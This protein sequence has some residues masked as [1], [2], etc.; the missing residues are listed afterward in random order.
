MGSGIVIKGAESVKGDLRRFALRISLRY[1]IAAGLWILFSDQIVGALFRDANALLMAQTYKGMAFVLVTSIFLFL[2]LFR[3]MQLLEEERE[4]TA[5]AQE[6]LETSEQ[7]YRNMATYSL[8]PKFVNQGGRVVYA[9]PA[10]AALFGVEKSTDIVGKTPYDLFAPEYHDLIRERIASLTEIGHSVEAIHE[11]IIRRDGSEVDVEVSASFFPYEK[12]NAVH[13]ILRDITKQIAAQE[14]IEYQVEQLKAL[15]EIDQTILNSEDLDA[16]LSLCLEHTLQL[17][18]VDAAL[19]VIH[20]TIVSGIEKIFHVGFSSDKNTSD[21]ME[22]RISVNQM[23]ADE[24]LRLF[25]SDLR[26]EEDPM[27][28]KG[29]IAAEA[30][31]SLCRVPLIAKGEVKGVIEVFKR[32]PIAPDTGWFDYYDTLAGQV[33]IAIDNYQLYRGLKQSLEKITNAYDATIAGW[34]RAMDLRDEETEGHTQRVAQLAVDI[35]KKMGLEGESIDHIKRGALLHD[36][37]KLGIPDNI[38]LKPGKLSAEEWEIMRK[39]PEFAYELLSPIEYLRP[40][41]EIPYCHHEKW[42]G[43]GYPRGLKGEEIPL[44]ARIFA[45]VDVWDALR[46]D[47]PYREKWSEERAI[48]YIRSQA[49]FHFDPKVTEVF[50]KFIIDL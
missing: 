12:K 30:F 44:S 7:N 24:K 11:K 29:V 6:A 37:G 28:E 22:N 4:H 43:S 31:I 39:H 41:L 2:D 36:M 32:D 13:V 16:V 38:L 35:A 14:Q 46:S 23:I 15:R 17:L 42:D 33:A 1:F 19:I 20:K 45:V 40:A 34:S 26:M 5:L 8:L 49:G 50:L 47:R 25:I 10:C 9:N 3:R 27:I 21:L 48:T 18:N